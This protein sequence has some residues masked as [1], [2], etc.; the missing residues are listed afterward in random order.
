MD[1]QKL[2][3]AITKALGYTENGGKPDVNNIKKGKTGETKSVFQFTPATWKN[4]S[5]QIFGKEVPIT[6]DTE[7]YV[8]KSKVEKWLEQGHSPKQIASMWNAGVGEPNAYTGKFSDGSSSKGTNKKYG[9]KYDVP[10]YAEKVKKYTDEFLGDDQE[11]K[12]ENPTESNPNL[13]SVLAMMQPKESQNSTQPA[14][15]TSQQ[16]SP[17]LS[18]LLQGLAGIKTGTN[19]GMMKSKNLS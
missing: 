13:K 8:V 11:N 18:G 12:N 4:Y 14:N 6:P 16:N 15:T 9:V 10:G 7:T 17:N 3:I 5:H 2:A 19:P 1:N